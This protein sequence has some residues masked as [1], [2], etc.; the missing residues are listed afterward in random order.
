LREKTDDLARREQGKGVPHAPAIDW[1]RAK[2]TPYRTQTAGPEGIR[3]STDVNRPWHQVDQH[4]GV[5]IIA[6]IRRQNDRPGRGYVCQPLD[7][8]IVTQ[9]AQRGRHKIAGRQVVGRGRLAVP[10]QSGVVKGWARSPSQAE[11]PA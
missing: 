9:H 4:I 1:E 5:E 2:S 11:R 10:P 3:S 7:D 6:V 8:D